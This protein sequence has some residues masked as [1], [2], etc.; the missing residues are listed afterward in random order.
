MGHRLSG[1]LALLAMPFAQ[2]ACAS[3]TPAQA[4]TTTLQ[5]RPQ[6][7]PCASAF[8]AKATAVRQLGSEPFASMLHAEDP[9]V[10]DQG[11]SWLISFW[12]VKIQK[13]SSLSI[14]VQKTTCLS[15]WQS[16]K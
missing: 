1:A 13:P 15:R 7:G 5:A 4:P 16:A 8:A 3:P 9:L 14:E 11:D 2:L 6:T 10:R 12:A